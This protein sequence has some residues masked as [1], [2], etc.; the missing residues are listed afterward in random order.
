[1]LHFRFMACVLACC[2]VLAIGSLAQDGRLPKGEGNM[3][4]LLV[5]IDD[6]AD[7]SSFSDL[8]GALNDVVDMKSLLIENFGFP[9]DEEHI[10]VLTDNCATRS[11]IVRTF[12]RHLIDKANEETVVVF[13]YSGHGSQVPDASGDENTDKLDETIVPHD[14]GR[15]DRPNRDITDDQLHALMV[16][17]QGIT[18]HITWVL[19]SCHSGSGSKGSGRVRSAQSDTRQPEHLADLDIGGKGE[20]G[21]G[22]GAD[23]PRYVLIAAARPDEKAREVRVEGEV[24]GALTY[25]LTRQ[26]RQSR[27]GGVTYRDIMDQVRAKV[28]AVTYHHPQLEGTDPDRLVFGTESLPA[29][30]YVLTHGKLNA[31]EITLAAGQAHGVTEGS[32]YALYDPGEKDFHENPEERP[33]IEVMKVGIVESRAKLLSGSFLPQSRAIEIRHNYPDASVRVVFASPSEKTGRIRKRLA[34]LSHIKVVA[35]KDGYDLLLREGGGQII[36]EGAAPIEIAPRISLDDPNL[37]EKVSSQLAQW[38]KW[39]NILDLNNA[40]SQLE[41]DFQIVGASEG[42]SKGSAFQNR[43]LDLTIGPE[44]AFRFQVT[45]NSDKGLFIALID[46]S[47]N[48]SVSLLHPLDGEEDKLAPGATWSSGEFDGSGLL[49]KNVPYLRDVVKLIVTAEYTDFRFVQQD[50]IQGRPRSVFSNPLEA[51]L[52]QAALGSKTG[53]GRRRELSAD[54]WL[55]VDRVFEIR[56]QPSADGERE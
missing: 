20:A 44:D 8:D 23:E 33:Q 28:A 3:L 51:L 52:A 49:D 53:G 31:T 35:E 24:R 56:H 14:S 25:H 29:K 22:L 21:K 47:S 13:H 46:V 4:A 30:R 45:N 16:E 27:S 26:I 50:P 6:Y 32:I 12:Q 18:P 39:L 55:V 15:G 7:N 19:D 40:T 38:A 5:G 10:M 36:T 42:G 34:G 48:G 43:E 54:D 17:L 1:M 2:V 9:D 11:N 41:V 37:V